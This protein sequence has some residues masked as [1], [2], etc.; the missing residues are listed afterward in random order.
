MY[1]AS[2]LT[3]QVPE[4][5]DSNAA[6]LA[7]VTATAPNSTPITLQWKTRDTAKALEPRPLAKSAAQSPGRMAI[8]RPNRLVSPSPPGCNVSPNTNR[9]KSDWYRSAQQALAA[10]WSVRF[11]S[12]HLSGV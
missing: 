4:A 5:L 8:S 7:W 11:K 9:A 2:P 10:A 12:S 3:K 6:F 1:S